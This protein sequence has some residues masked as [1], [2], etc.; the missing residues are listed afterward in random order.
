M[1]RAQARKGSPSLLIHNAPLE[2]GGQREGGVATYGLGPGHDFVDSFLSEDC[3][4]FHLDIG[5]YSTGGNS[6]HVNLLYAS[7]R[8][9]H[10]E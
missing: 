7:R 10:F 1:R 6:I 5:D 2:V 3:N 8:S 9:N 4:G